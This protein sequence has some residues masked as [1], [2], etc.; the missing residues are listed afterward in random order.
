MLPIISKQA[1]KHTL[2]DKSYKFK[3]QIKISLDKYRPPIIQ[4]MAAH[5]VSQLVVKKE[6][7]ILVH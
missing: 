4:E 6:G 1:I 2:I 3:K 7:T 5:K